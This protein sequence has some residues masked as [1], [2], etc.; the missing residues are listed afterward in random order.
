VAGDEALTVDLG[1]VTKEGCTF[2]TQKFYE[3][4]LTKRKELENVK[5]IV[6]PP[7]TRGL[8]DESNRF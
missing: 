2:G 4:F 7:Q 3:S 5:K 6:P 1:G 8:S